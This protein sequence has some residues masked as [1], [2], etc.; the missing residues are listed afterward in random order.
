[1]AQKKKTTKKNDVKKPEVKKADVKKREPSSNKGVKVEAA[2]QKSKEKG[3]PSAILPYILML[4]SVV[5]AICFITVKLFEIDDGAGV[6]GNAIQWFFC[7]LFGSA[8]FFLP[9]VL[10][11][12]GVN[13]LIFNLRWFGG[14]KRKP[15]AEHNP[16]IDRKR[17]AVL[18]V[19][20]LI[21]LGLLSVLFGVIANEGESFSASD[22]WSDA[23][24]GSESIV[25]GF[26]GGGIAAFMIMCFEK[27]ISV[28]LLVFGVVASFLF[29]IDVTPRRIVMWIQDKREEREEIVARIEQVKQLSN[30]KKR[31]LMPR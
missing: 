29:A 19:S 15:T 18:V 22:L 4:F 12:I 25:G 6:I 14:S 11:Y 3:M 23:A 27:V 13:K 10:F 31:L 7:G 16:A 2:P 8:A 30:A 26:F 17:L 1:M 5:L 28:I 20:S 9:I 24:D 21:C